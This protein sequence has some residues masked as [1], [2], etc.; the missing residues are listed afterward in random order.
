MTKIISGSSNPQLAS[1][2]ASYAGT[3]LTPVKISRFKDGEI[4][5]KILESIRGYDVF[6]V[7]ST[8]CPANDTLMELLLLI[9]AAKRAS[10]KSVTVVIP[11]FGYA[12]QDRKAEP[13]EPISAKVVANIIQTA[14]ADRVLTMDLH[15]RQITGFFDIPV[16]DLWAAP[17]L[18]NYFLKKGLKKPVI[19]SPDAGGTMRARHMGKLLDAP[20]AVIDK[21]RSGHNEA[22][23]MNILGDVKGKDAILLDDMIDSGG[24]ICA[25]SG[26]VK[27]AGAKNVYICAT[28]GI[29]SGDALKN[30]QKSAAQEVLVTNT[31]MHKRDNK[32]KI[33]VVSVAPMLGQAIKNIAAKESVSAL[34]GA[35]LQTKLVV[36]DKHGAHLEELK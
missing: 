25:A 9:D 18:R 11:Y 12:R 22:E 35:E 31:I 17:I 8:C 30:V 24:T 33:K 27:K 6:I 21:R 3:K 34:S 5:V 19:V 4:Y 29:F 23:V 15:S 36:W 26:A 13:R 10:A 32:A 20:I 2:I 7:Q 14:G 1:E 16:D 28:H